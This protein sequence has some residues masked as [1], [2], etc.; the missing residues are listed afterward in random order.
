MSGDAASQSTTAVN[1][2]SDLAKGLAQ[3]VSL[4]QSV[5]EEMRLTR[6][7]RELSD[8]TNEEIATIV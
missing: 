3:L 7:A 8:V 6:I 1:S 5:V 4:Q 2:H